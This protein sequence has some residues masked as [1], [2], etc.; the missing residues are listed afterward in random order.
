MHI[1]PSISCMYKAKNAAPT[2]IDMSGHVEHA[3]I[4]QHHV[5]FAQALRI[6]AL[7]TK[8][9]QSQKS[10]IPQ[11]CKALP[12]SYCLINKAEQVKLKYWPS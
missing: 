4:W 11:S 2:A 3:I 12:I 5:G 10:Q 6:L 8:P 9:R 7:V 1:A